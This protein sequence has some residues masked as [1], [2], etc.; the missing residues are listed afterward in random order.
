VFVLARQQ[1]RL[2][3]G[4]RKAGWGTGPRTKLLFVCFEAKKL[5]CQ[6]ALVRSWTPSWGVLGPACTGCFAHVGIRTE[7]PLGCMADRFLTLCFFHNTAFC[8]HP[9]S[10]HRVLWKPRG[11]KWD[12]VLSSIGWVRW[13][14]GR[15]HVLCRDKPSITIGRSLGHWDGD[16]L[17]VPNSFQLLTSF[18]QNDL[19]GLSIFLLEAN[20]LGMR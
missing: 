1:L 19:L 11:T 14:P 10:H 18:L 8:L 7:G 13:V 3:L 4:K 9:N 2:K 5:A 12:P 17:L 20:F 6:W 15:V 16:G